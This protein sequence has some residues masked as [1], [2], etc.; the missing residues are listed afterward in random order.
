GHGQPNSGPAAA[1]VF[2]SRHYGYTEALPAA[3]RLARQATRQ[4]DGKGAP[5]YDTR[6]VDLFQGPG[7]LQA[8]ALAAPTNKNLDSYTSA[9]IPGGPATQPG[10]QDGR[11][12]GPA[13]EHA[14]RAGERLPGGD[15][16]HRPP[17]HRVRVRIPAPAGD[18]GPPQCRPRRLPQIPGRHP[19]SAVRA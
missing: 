12:T 10:H 6:V 7:S 11:G 5:G 19:A 13:A 9:T 15:R 17:R 16:G 18:A 14:M 3:W 1:R 2:T 4:W 8:W